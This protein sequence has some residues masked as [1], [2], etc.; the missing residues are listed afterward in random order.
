MEDPAVDS[1]LWCEALTRIT[2]SVE[3][4]ILLQAGIFFAIVTD[5]NYGGEK[6]KRFLN[7]LCTEM[8]KLYKGNINFIH[9]Q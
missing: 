8:V 4:N 5:L 2:G 6:S 1:Q 7:D 3:I 9:R